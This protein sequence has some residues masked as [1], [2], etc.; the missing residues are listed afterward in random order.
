MAEGILITGGAGFLGS[1][2]AGL[3]LARGD[4]V[5]VLDE[6]LDQEPVGEGVGDAEPSQAPFR[7]ALQ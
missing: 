2:I 3:L 6:A 4:K 5:V 1:H 7:S